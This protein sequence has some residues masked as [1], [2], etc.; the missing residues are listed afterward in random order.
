MQVKEYKD[1]SYGPDTRNVLDAYIVD[2]GGR[3]SPVLIFFHGGGYVGGGK[4][5]ILSNSLMQECLEAG[6]SVVTCNYRF[7]T[8]DP[9]PAPMEDGTRAIQFVRG[10]ADSWGLDPGRVASSGSSAGGHI[11]LWNALKGNLA[12]PDSSDPIERISSEVCG[13][14]G[15]GT[16][17]SKDQR[18]YEGIYEGPHIQPNLALFYGIPSLDDL[19]RP[20]ILKLAEE[21]SAI[22][23]MSPAAPP[24]FMVYHYELDMDKPHIPADAP[25]G[26]VIHHP[27]HGYVLKQK[28]DALG[29]PFI[30]RHVGDPVRPGEM[31]E[32]LLDCFKAVR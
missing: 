31:V 4:A 22:N 20:E 23:H 29:K 12:K 3:P 26:E 14:I 13:F 17:A 30:L 16:Q 7:I 18:F 9:F 6:I 10:M 19:Y 27:M 5:E 1:V 15:F 28:Y 21:A 25:V 8:Q 11:A 24:A 2:L 32:F